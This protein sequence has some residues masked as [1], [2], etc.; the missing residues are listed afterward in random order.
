MLKAPF[1][2]F[3]LFTTTF[4]IAQDTTTAK[5]KVYIDCR[6]GCDMRFFKTEINI[7]DF[8]IDRDAADV[9]VLITAQRLGSGGSQFQLN[10]YGQ[11]NYEDYID[12][13]YFTTRPNASSATVREQMVRYLMF[14]FTPLVAKTAYGNDIKIAM[15]GKNSANENA[16]NTKDKWN[17]WV[18]NVGVNGQLSADQ[19]YRTRIFNSS[20]SAN[21]VTDKLKV[22]F[23]GHG[24][25]YHTRYS[26]PSGDT[27][28]TYVVKNSDYGFNVHAIK[29]ITAHWS[30]GSRGSLS[31][32]TFSNIR[33]KLYFKPSL[34]YN[35]Y[36]FKDVNNRYLVL[37]YGVDINHFN[38]YD[39]TL[40][41][42]IEETLVGHQLS[43]TLSLNK[44][45][46]SINTGMHY[47]NFLNDRKLN[48]MGISS[49]VDVRV[50]GALSFYINTNASIVHDQVNLV[51]GGG[52]EQEIL[53]RKRQIASN[54]NYYT[55]FGVNF[56][57]GSILNNFV[58]PRFDG[59]G[60]F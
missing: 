54:F 39:T 36:N 45:W 21:R 14:G 34:E 27:T 9:H 46:G 4:I 8:V 59:Y 55:S 23:D 22:H 32:N 16:E 52:T 53:T 17:Y 33:R 5:L 50:T 28:T 49:H 30:I 10:F 11:N 25:L 20:I 58:N 57:F 37:R 29:S 51:K 12:T 24:A 13:L 41:N 56:R 15:K 40:F 48:S 42:K 26:Y 43:L 6:V 47:R 18:Y 19:V 44:K 38:Y 7:L 3:A 35:I 1:L 60:G 2:F 31:N